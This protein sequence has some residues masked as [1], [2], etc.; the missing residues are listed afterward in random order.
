M[1]HLTFILTFQELPG[2]LRWSAFWL[3]S[4]ARNTLFSPKVGLKPPPW[5]HFGTSWPLLWHLSFVFC[6]SGP[7]LCNLLATWL[8][9]GPLG[10][11]V[12]SHLA[13]PIYELY[14]FPCGKHINR[15]NRL[16]HL[17]Y[18]GGAPHAPKKRP[19]TPKKLP[20]TS[21][22]EPKGVP[23]LPQGSP[24][25]PQ[26]HPKAPQKC[27]RVATESQ[28][29]AQGHQGRPKLPQSNQ[30]EQKGRPSVPQRRPK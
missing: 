28:N 3:Q 10:C 9:D 24:K 30:S 11:H 22:R 21:Q 17:F 5:P 12:G 18:P 13:A 29:H 8:H 6:V 26:S 25:D 20:K 4:G 23:K 16:S 19:K 1:S 14:G 27:R 7:H 2:G 15:K